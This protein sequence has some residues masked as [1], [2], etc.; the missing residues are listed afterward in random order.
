MEVLVHRA[1]KPGNVAPITSPQYVTL[2]AMSFRCSESKCLP[3]PAAASPSLYNNSMTTL[4]FPMKLKI[5][6]QNIALAKMTTHM[7]CLYL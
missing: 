1:L 7:D 6:Q 5:F 2:S 4:R 3:I